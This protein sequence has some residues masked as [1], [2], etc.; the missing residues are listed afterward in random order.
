MYFYELVSEKRANT[1][2][3]QRVLHLSVPLPVPA[4]TPV[5]LCYARLLHLLDGPNQLH[6]FHNTEDCR[7]PSHEDRKQVSSL[8]AAGPHTSFQGAG[9][10]FDSAP[11]LAGKLIKVS[12]ATSTLR[13]KQMHEQLEVIYTTGELLGLPTISTST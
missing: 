3:L 5:L 13:S 1:P 4:N 10:T 8:L 11:P 2:L 6:L 9:R 12:V 7:E